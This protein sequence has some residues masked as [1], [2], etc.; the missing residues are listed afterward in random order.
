MDISVYFIGLR[1]PFLFALNITIE[2][3][4]EICISKKYEEVSKRWFS[5]YK[6]IISF[7]KI[8]NKLKTEK[9]IEK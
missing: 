3:N 6:R 1:Q 7:K 9:C 2:I 8:K 4:R 5:G